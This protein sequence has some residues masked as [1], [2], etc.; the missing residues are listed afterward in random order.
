ML[1][2]RF[3]IAAIVMIIFVQIYEFAIHAG[4]LSGLYGSLASVWRPEEDMQS[5]MPW[6]ILGQVLFAIM[7][8][9]LYTCS[10]C[11][12]TVSQGVTFGLI[13]GVL[14][15]SA[16]LIFYAVLPITFNLM[17]MW[18]ITGIIE[19]VLMGLILSFLLKESS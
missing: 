10:K 9:V 2:K 1:N 11:R 3:I 6:M 8:C 19:C 18:V 15:S 12:N 5:F 4:A 7:F 13:V 16:S 14:F 17:I